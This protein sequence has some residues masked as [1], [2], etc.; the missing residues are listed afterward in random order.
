[1]AIATT[2][3]ATGTFFIVL[4]IAL[5]TIYFMYRNEPELQKPAPR[6]TRVINDE[7]FE[8]NISTP[9]KDSAV[10]ATAAE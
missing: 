6:F 10:G 1:M 7:H 3:I 5:A 4:G 8:H 9:V 2:L